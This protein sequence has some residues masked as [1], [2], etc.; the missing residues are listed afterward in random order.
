[1]KNK[2]NKLKSIIAVALGFAIC[3]VSVPIIGY[4]KL[5][6]A[7]AKETAK[8]YIPSNKVI[9]N[10]SFETI[11]DD[12]VLQGWESCMI[13][14]DQDLSKEENLINSTMSG[15]VGVNSEENYINSIKTMLGDYDVYGAILSPIYPNSYAPE[16]T[17]ATSALMINSGK[18]INTNKR[19]Y[20][21]VTYTY[22]D[23][24]AIFAESTT[25]SLQLSSNYPEVGQHFSYGGKGYDYVAEEDGWVYQEEGTTKEVILSD[26]SY[27]YTQNKIYQTYT[28]SSNL[29]LSAYKYY[30]LV[31][32]VNTTT[33]AKANITLLE[34][35]KD[36]TNASFNNITTNNAWVD[37]TYYI[38]TNYG[39]IGNVNFKIQLSLGDET[40]T[41]AG[42]VFFDDVE[43]TEVQ[44]QTFY[45]ATHNSTTN[46]I[47]L[48]D[49]KNSISTITAFENDTMQNNGWSWDSSTS[50]TEDSFTVITESDL[51]SYST[52]TKEGEPN[53][54]L[55]VTNST[56]NTIKFN[57]KKT[58]VSPFKYYRVSLWARYD[59]TDIDIHKN[60]TKFSHD[61]YSIVLNGTLNG[62]I[63]STKSY[64]IDAFDDSQ[65]STSEG[66]NVNNYWKEVSFYIQACPIYTTDVW[67]TIS[68][69]KG[70]AF[71]FDN[72][73]IEEITDSEYTSVADK[74]LALTST[75]P[76]ETVPNGFFN[77]VSSK[78]TPAGLYS[79]SDW[80]LA[81]GDLSKDN[82]YILTTSDAETTTY[83]V[84]DAT[85]LDLEENKITDKTD[86]ENPVEYTL[87]ALDGKYKNS[88]GT[89][90]ITVVKDSEFIYGVAVG[91]D[92]QNI[93]D[94][95]QIT[96]EDATFVNPNNKLENYLVINNTNT[97]ARP[98]F[99]Y[100]SDK[101]SISSGKYNVLS[102]YVYNE[103]SSGSV[104]KINLLN[105]S[106]ECISTLDIKTASNTAEAD[107]WTKYVFYIKGGL[108]S[109]SLYV[110]VEYGDGKTEQTGA[111]LIK[112]VFTAPS[113]SNAFGD[114]E[115]KSVAELNDANTRVVSLVG[116]TFTE[117]GAEIEANKYSATN[118]KLTT[119]NQDNAKMYI[120]DTTASEN[121]SYK[122]ENSTSP[123]VFVLTNNTT[124]TS[125]ANL[126]QKYTLQKS[127][128]YKLSVTAKALNLPTGKSGT[129]KFTNT[130]SSLCVDSNEYK[131][132]VLYFATG[133]DSITAIPEISLI[134]CQGTIVV[135]NIKVEKL[136][137]TTYNSGIASITSETPNIT[138]VDLRNATTT[139]NG[140]DLPAIDDSNQTLEILFATFS[141][142]LLVVALI[143]AI[144]LTK[145]NF[146]KKNKGAKNKVDSSDV[147]EQKG[148]V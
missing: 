89:A 52:F 103:L 79:P 22:D 69:P 18:I 3:F 80:T 66:G 73:T 133:T 126:N 54:C 115:D 143:I 148:F 15:I 141:S 142:L 113:S 139:N 75:L 106:S 60:P 102:V 122:Y 30:K 33:D 36:Y 55:Q 85:N 77:S 135:D 71:L 123:F 93:V 37:Y 95:T 53:Y 70:T 145:V 127:S 134:D 109:E 86:R 44:Y 6:T 137:E 107:N 45:S 23:V 7:S 105:S 88:T 59:Y 91:K 131:E 129:I 31:I 2:T 50:A 118:M 38:A 4:N 98:Q 146:K 65:A 24:N 39:S 10:G 136:T 26:Y 87:D 112:T 117:I 76:T 57:T 119:S 92:F 8:E 19:I 29:Q 111:L 5:F 48:R 35:L 128:F 17:T 58:Q 99:V 68:V 121:A 12:S 140:E 78:K 104:A 138:K 125:C 63:V 56:E 61:K 96:T 32:R 14:S 110:Q 13:K 124:E 100:T 94:G 114:N 42:T 72:Y 82:N 43:L 46:I 90:F 130:N 97:V 81:L 25:E 34:D 83:T 16:N 132:Y 40:S 28:S 64:D 84:L 49:E 21:I 41:S 74:K 144:V 67:F 120:L 9:S 47:N 20:T 147:D 116:T 108:A 27:A 101:F 1:M 51:I 11:S 62:N